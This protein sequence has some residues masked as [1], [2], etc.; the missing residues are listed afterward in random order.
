LRKAERD[1]IEGKIEAEI[2]E[3]YVAGNDTARVYKVVPEN[4]VL[5]LHVPCF[6]VTQTEKKLGVPK[7]P[8]QYKKEKKDIL[9]R[10]RWRKNSEGF[11]PKQ[12]DHYAPYIVLGPKEPEEVVPSPEITTRYGRK[13]KKRKRFMEA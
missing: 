12:Q 11:S 5:S 8:P 1:E 7:K 2:E 10:Q 6:R 4:E 3:T 13:V 9:L